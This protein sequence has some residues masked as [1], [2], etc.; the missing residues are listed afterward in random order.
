ML[1]FYVFTATEIHQFFKI[2]TFI[3][4]YQEHKKE[5]PQLTFIHFLQ[6]H[7]G[8][9]NTNDA[10]FAKDM[11]LPFKT[12]SNDLMS[13][14]GFWVESYSIP[15]RPSVQ[16]HLPAKLEVYKVNLIASYLSKIWQPPKYPSVC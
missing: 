9:G 3:E 1:S 16:F 13:T 12:Y 6:I 15:N 10:D 7:Y 5:N 11:K 14:P 8:Q 4:H 2:N